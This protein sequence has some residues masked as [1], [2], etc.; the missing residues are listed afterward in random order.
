MAGS[1]TEVDVNK[2]I[3]ASQDRKLSTK[4]RNFVNQFAMTPQEVE[5][6]KLRELTD[7]NLKELLTS[8]RDAPSDDIFLTLADEHDKILGARAEFIKN[9]QA[10]SKQTVVK[11]PTILDQVTDFLQSIWSTK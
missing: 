5:G 9:A 7:A 11:Q 8:M 4:H 10:Q 3:K 2:F 1:Y 6:D